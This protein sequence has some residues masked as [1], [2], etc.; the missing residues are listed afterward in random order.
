MN[1]IK[2]CSN[3]ETDSILRDLLNNAVREIMSAVSAERGS[4]FLFDSEHKELVLDSFY[5]LGGL[6]LE[7][8]RQ[9]V[10]EG[11]SGRVIDIKTPILVKNIDMDSRFKRNGFTHYKTNSFISV[12]LVTSKG[13]LGLVNITDKANGDSFSEKD[14][15]FAATLCRYATRLADNLLNL[16]RYASVGKLAGGIVHEINNPLDG[17]LRYT[18]LLLKLADNNSVTREYLLETKKGLDRLANITRSLVEFSHQLN[19]NLSKTKRYVDVCEIINESLDA[20]K[21]K[22]NGNIQV[23][24]RLGH[25]SLWLQDL[26]ISH[27]LTN[28]IKNA[29]DAMCDGGLLDIALDTAGPMVKIT[30]SDTGYGIPCELKGRIFE[31]FFTTKSVDKGTG[32]GLAICKE[33]I[34][35]YDGS[36]DV[37]SSQS[38]GSAFTISIPKKYLRNE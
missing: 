16:E 9:G 34:A 29:M 20:F 35:R 21:D 11:I 13:L 38:E 12:P 7:G 18:N 25:N 26:G 23:N 17:C 4:L 27:I 5:S 8:I 31:P 14:L 37:R 15:E 30:V 36:I 2:L 33:L 6:R 28:I 32:L 10:G 22:L 1:E 3:N 24:K 19:T